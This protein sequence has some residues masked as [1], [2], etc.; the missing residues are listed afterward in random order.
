MVMHLFN[1]VYVLTPIEELFI[2]EEEPSV[3]DM[4]PQISLFLPP[5]GQ[6]LKEFF[7]AFD[8]QSVIVLMDLDRI[9]QSM[10]G[11]DKPFAQKVSLIL[12]L[13]G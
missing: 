9:D 12:R 5:V 11:S 4:D 1:Q 6:G 2:L 10:E 3:G 13:C 7:G 8:E